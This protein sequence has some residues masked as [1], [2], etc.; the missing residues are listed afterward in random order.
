MK[1]EQVLRTALAWVALAII[2]W[3]GVSLVVGH[4]ANPLQALGAV[5]FLIAVYL[6]TPTRTET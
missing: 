1:N 5:L 4:L 6:V 3:G 2:I